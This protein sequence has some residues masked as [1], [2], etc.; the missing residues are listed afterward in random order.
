MTVEEKVQAKFKSKDDFNHFVRNQ[1]VSE[2]V[3][4]S[5]FEL[6]NDEEYNFVA[7]MTRNEADNL[8]SEFTFKSSAYKILK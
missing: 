6:D 5:L 8:S 7:T 3:R 2:S 4:H 1:N